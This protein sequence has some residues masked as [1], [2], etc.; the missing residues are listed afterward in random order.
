MLPD[1]KE[2]VPLATKKLAWTEDYALEKIL[3]IVCRTQLTLIA[4]H[5]LHDDSKKERFMDSNGYLFD[6]VRLI[7]QRVAAGIPCYSVEWRRRKSV[8]YETSKP[9]TIPEY[10]ESC[11]PECLLLKSFAKL[12]EDFQSEKLMKQ[13]KRKPKAVK[14]CKTTKE[15]TQKPITEFF[16]EAKTTLMPSD[17][18][19]LPI[20]K[21]Y[22]VIEDSKIKKNAVT[23]SKKTST[24]KLNKNDNLKPS[25]NVKVNHT[26]AIE[27]AKRELMRKVFE[28]SPDQRNSAMISHTSFPSGGKENIP[29]QSTPIQVSLEQ[30]IKTHVRDFLNKK[31]FFDKLNL[32]VS[33]HH[34][35]IAY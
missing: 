26:P 28:E 4:E 32:V 34:I 17:T 13:K 31:S 6:P 15:I 35:P 29:L 21:V 30:R 19:R 23:N 27:K 12:V 1:V 22:G 20:T 14:V 18:N 24:C 11:E 3:P 10:Y 25:D 5:Q 7:K 8:K 16:S 33:T 2:F 9:I